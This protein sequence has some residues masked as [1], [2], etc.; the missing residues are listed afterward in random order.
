MQE[1]TPENLE[2]FV[3]KY[4]YNDPVSKTLP[5][6]RKRVCSRTK[7]KNKK[8]LARIG[9]DKVSNEWRTKR[10][11]YQIDVMESFQSREEPGSPLNHGYQLQDGFCIP[12][13]NTDSAL[14]KSLTDMH[15]REA[16]KE[17]TDSEQDSDIDSDDSSGESSDADTGIDD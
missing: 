12:I 6:M 8:T 9:P 7:K 3:V 10:I 5:E 15:T 14:P 13:T 4:M 16:H 17:N 2:K 1:Q 11:L